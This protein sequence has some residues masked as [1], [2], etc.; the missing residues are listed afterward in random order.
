MTASGATL[1]GYTGIGKRRLNRLLM[2]ILVRLPLEVGASQRLT[3]HGVMLL[4]RVQRPAARPLCD[5]R[6]HGSKSVRYRLLGTCAGSGEMPPEAAIKLRSSERSASLKR[7]KRPEFSACC[8]L[9]DIIR[10]RRGRA[11]QQA[12]LGTSGQPPGKRLTEVRAGVFVFL[13]RGASAFLAWG[14]CGGRPWIVLAVQIYFEV[15]RIER[16]TPSLRTCLT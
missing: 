1:D 10:G 8:D 15:E 16:V 13:A 5:A 9:A 4:D 3:S 6:T 11:Y 14:S 2:R 12:G 7:S